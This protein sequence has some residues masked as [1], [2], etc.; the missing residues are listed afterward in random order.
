MVVS[1]PIATRSALPAHASRRTAAAPARRPTEQ[2]RRAKIGGLG[3]ERRRRLTDPHNVGH[4]SG[5]R[6]DSPAR[7]CAKA[8]A[9]SCRS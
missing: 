7:E 9:L 3:G 4:R 2:H 1:P 5:P 8:F 6:L